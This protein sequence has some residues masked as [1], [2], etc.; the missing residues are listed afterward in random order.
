MSLREYPNN[1]TL[2]KSIRS[3]R[4]QYKINSRNWIWQYLIRS[5]RGFI[6]LQE[7]TSGTVLGRTL[8]R[9][10]RRTFRESRLCRAGINAKTRTKIVSVSSAKK[11]A[12]VQSCCHDPPFSST[13]WPEPRA[14]T[15]GG[16]GRYSR[17]RSTPG[18]R[19]AEHL[20]DQCPPSQHTRT[21]GVLFR[22]PW[23]PL[24]VTLANDYSDRFGLQLSTDLSSRTSLFARVLPNLWSAST[25]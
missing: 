17:R 24:R 9:A 1:P 3:A 10:R 20:N 21:S 23:T 25:T 16:G 14:R 19:I 4:L 5:S 8:R 15:R 22:P 7:E 18:N 11:A 13:S 2:V 12:T 6:P